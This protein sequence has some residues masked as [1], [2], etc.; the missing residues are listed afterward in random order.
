MH[1]P[2]LALNVESDIEGGLFAVLSSLY[3][4]IGHL[5]D[6][7][8]LKPVEDALDIMKGKLV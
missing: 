3:G 1:D 4:S 6:I 2:V 8:D 7:V 5:H